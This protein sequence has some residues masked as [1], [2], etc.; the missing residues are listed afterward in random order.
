MEGMEGTHKIREQMVECL[1]MD[2]FENIFL[3][4]RIGFS[5]LDF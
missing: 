5:I 3:K 2:N 4:M 1:G